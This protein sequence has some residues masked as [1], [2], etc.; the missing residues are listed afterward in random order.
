MANPN[1]SPCECISKLRYLKNIAIK[2]FMDAVEPRGAPE[3]GLFGIEFP[4]L[5]D[6]EYALNRL[7]EALHDYTKNCPW[8]LTPEAR[9]LEDILN[10]YKQLLKQ[11]KEGEEELE[12]LRIK[13]GFHT[14]I[15]D[16]LV[17]ALEAFT[18]SAIEG[19][20]N[21]TADCKTRG[22][23]SPD[24]YTRHYCWAL[25]HNIE[26]LKKEIT[27]ITEEA[28]NYLTAPESLIQKASELAEEQHRLIAEYLTTCKVDKTQ[29]KRIEKALGNFSEDIDFHRERL[30]QLREWAS[31]HIQELKKDEKKWQEQVSQEEGCL[32]DIHTAVQ[33]YEKAVSVFLETEWT[34]LCETLKWKN[35]KPQNTTKC[36]A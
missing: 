18:T 35:T 2:D 9:E 20:Y 3:L 31:Q 25:L 5:E 7:E 30:D 4:E 14:V 6:V 12:D 8:E 26:A 32:W 36:Y 23:L 24:Q 1:V 27:D 28:D 10:K 33:N 22:P 29:A 11:M 13:L 17:E 21:N 19:I 15:T 16:A 34:S